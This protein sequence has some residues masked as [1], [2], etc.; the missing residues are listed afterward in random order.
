MSQCH[1]GAIEM[2]EV[3]EFNGFSLFQSPVIHTSRFVVEFQVDWENLRVLCHK[4]KNGTFWK[5]KPTYEYMLL[6]CQTNRGS[7]QLG[8]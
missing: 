7:T 5:F 3:H 8:P 1:F 2:E 6:E 4:N